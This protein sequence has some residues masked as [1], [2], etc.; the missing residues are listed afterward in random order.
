V[1]QAETTCICMQVLL[2]WAHCTTMKQYTILW[3]DD[4]DDDK[5]LMKEIL[6]RADKSF[7]I[8]EA[9]NGQELLEFLESVKYTAA[10]PCLIMMDIN[11]PITNNKATIKNIKADT[12][13]C[14]IPLIVFATPGYEEDRK[15]CKT[16][17]IEMVSKP[18]TYRDL[19]HALQ[20]TLSFCKFNDENKAVS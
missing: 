19:Q 1:L 5:A 8:V 20:K 18:S 16:Y 15:F 17:S 11:M 7:L 3:V 4:D 13:F 9:S 2:L 12:V 10:L 14:S 6:E